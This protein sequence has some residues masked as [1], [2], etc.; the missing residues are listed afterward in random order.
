VEAFKWYRKAAENNYADAQH[1]M[2]LFY[3]SGIGV[4]KD[5]VEAVKW[6]RKTAEQD[7]TDAQNNL[8]VHYAFGTGV[9]KDYVVGYK[10]ILLAAAK[11]SENAKELMTVLE[12]KMTPDQ[13]AEGQK[14]AHEFKPHKE[15]ASGNSNLP[16]NITTNGMIQISSPT[17]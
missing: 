17:K 1:N 4:A 10:W 7:I 13:I 11:G 9:A 5:D 6:Y 8:G 14:L 16:E 3:E 2:G 15:S 12:N